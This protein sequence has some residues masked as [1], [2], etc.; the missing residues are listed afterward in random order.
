MLNFHGRPVLLGHVFRGT[1]K[2]CRKWHILLNLATRGCPWVKFKFRHTSTLG[3][4]HSGQRWRIWD[5]LEP[6]SIFFQ[7]KITSL[8]ATRLSRNYT[9]TSQINFNSPHILVLMLKTI[10]C[11]SWLFMKWEQLPWK[12][13][14]PKEEIVRKPRNA[15]V[16]ERGND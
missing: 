6:H 12:A 4:S 10:E 8:N 14:L 13:S 5:P 15:F 1:L 16:K 7:K 9:F 3:E 2:K 11:W